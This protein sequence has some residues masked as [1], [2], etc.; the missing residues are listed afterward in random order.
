MNTPDPADLL[1]DAAALLEQYGWCQQELVSLDG[2]RCLVGSI[3]HATFNWAKQNAAYDPEDT[4]NVW[5][6][7]ENLRNLVRNRIPITFP[8]NDQYTE[9][10]WNDSEGRTADEVIDLLKHIAKDLRNQ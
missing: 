3:R 6:L 10:I 5:D 2:R 4:A 8:S 1:E 9:V 7:E